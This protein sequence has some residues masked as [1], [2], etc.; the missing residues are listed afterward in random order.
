VSFLR[1]RKNKRFG[2]KLRSQR[3]HQGSKNDD[4]ESEWQESRLSTMSKGVKLRPLTVLI[5]LFIMVLIL[6]YVLNSYQ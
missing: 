1:Q 5:V 6:M 3:E 4:F 2:Y